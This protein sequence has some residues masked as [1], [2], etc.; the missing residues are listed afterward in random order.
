MFLATFEILNSPLLRS[1]IVLWDEYIRCNPYLLIVDA[2]FFIHFVFTWYRSYKHDGFKIDLWHV[3]VFKLFV[4][5]FFI[6]YPFN[7]SIYNFTST[8]HHLF[9]YYKHIDIAFLITIVGY[10]CMYI[11]REAAKINTKRSLIEVFFAPL[12]RLTENNI[13]ND[14]SY[15]TLMFIAN[16]LI[17]FVIYI[18]LKYDVL[19]NPRSYF[20]KDSSLRP[21]YNV[22]VT[23]YPLFLMYAG[24]RFIN[25]NTFKN[26]IIF[27]VQFVLA[28]FLGTR[29]SLLEP[30]LILV[31]LFYASKPKIF[32]VRN[33]LLIA[34]TFV[35]LTFFSVLLRLGSEAK[36]MKIGKDFFHGNTYSDNR[37]FGWILAK[38][39]GQYLHGRTYI[40]GA[41]SIVPRKFSRFREKWAFGIYTAK[42]IG[43]DYKY[44]A[45]LRLGF[46]GESFL[47]FGILGV[48][49]LGLVLGFVLKKL[50]FF[51][52]KTFMTLDDPIKAFAGI[53]AWNFIMC[54]NVSINFGALYSLMLI[55]VLSAGVRQAFKLGTKTI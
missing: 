51:V 5:P 2:V 54:L 49:F 48:M 45:G 47:N 3:M 10:V 14:V 28:L 42:V 20:L 46:F 38:W 19:F 33:I 7:G 40:A 1:K 43:Y 9:A 30:L 41:M 15:Y 12:E 52:K 8:G 23:I 24:V 32:T 26:R 44:F 13:K 4:L 16:A 31:I 11:G 36:N 39:N 37:D 53:F 25:S 22:A 50:D 27:I 21:I 55:I 6:L 35:V 17:V 34:S 29:S 18:Q